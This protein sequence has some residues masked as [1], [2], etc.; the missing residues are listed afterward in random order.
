MEGLVKFEPREN[1][2]SAPKTLQSVAHGQISM[3]TR[4]GTVHN[5]GKLRASSILRWNF[6]TLN[7]VLNKAKKNYRR[8]AFIVWRKWKKVEP[9]VPLPKIFH[10]QLTSVALENRCR[11]EYLAT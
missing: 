6:F 10:H 5:K 8:T 7:F 1:I 3:K 11:K 2:F 4:I 9:E